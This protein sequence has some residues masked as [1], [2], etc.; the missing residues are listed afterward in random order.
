MKKS[1]QKHYL[2]LT[3]HELDVLYIAANHF[4]N[5]DCPTLEFEDDE[6]DLRRAL[7]RLVDR[8]QKMVATM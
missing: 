8:L 4:E 5:E 1:K 6:D 2:Q 7:T 3:R